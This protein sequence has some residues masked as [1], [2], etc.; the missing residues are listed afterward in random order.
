MKL[1]SLNTLLQ[2]GKVINARDYNLV[3][4]G[5]LKP[6]RNTYRLLSRSNKELGIIELHND[7]LRVLKGKDTKI[8]KNDIKSN[9][10]IIELVD[11]IIKYMNETMANSIINKIEGVV[12]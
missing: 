10:D 9:S 7:Y 11:N 8:F 2:I 4:D 3:L 5:D 6:S 12:K 1:N